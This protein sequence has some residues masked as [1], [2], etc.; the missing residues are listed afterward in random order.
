MTSTSYAAGHGPSAIIKAIL[1]VAHECIIP[2]TRESFARNGAP[3]GAA[4]L[5]GGSN[6]EPVAVAV[7]DWQACPIYHGETNCIIKYSQIPQERRPAPEHCIFFATHEPCSLCLSSLAWTGFRVIYFLFTYEDAH[8]MLKEKK[9]VEI[10]KEI[11]KVPESGS[12]G[13]GGKETD[14]ARPFY[15]KKNKFFSIY[16]MQELLGEV[17][18]NEERFRLQQQVAALRDAYEEFRRNSEDLLAG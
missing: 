9:D 12:A 14:H 2:L 1:K 13:E 15:N 3:F 10:I 7:N 17:E 18:D 16:S 8:R 4:V 11:F 6:L 5:D